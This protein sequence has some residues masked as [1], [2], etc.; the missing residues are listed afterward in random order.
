MQ[1]ELT[2]ATQLKLSEIFS[3]LQGEGP[4]AGQ[5]CVFL[6]L[7]LCNLRCDWCDTKYTWDFKAY[8]YEDEVREQPVAEVA[9]RLRQL[10]PRHLVITGGEPLLQQA[11]LANLLS[12]LNPEVFVE[13]ET[14]GTL[15]PN[16]M[17]CQRVQH[18]NVSPKLSNSGEA[19]A[20]RLRPEPLLR[21][22]ALEGAWLKLVLQADSDW[23]EAQALITATNW[24]LQR[25]LLMPQ[26]NQPSELTARSAPIAALAVRHGVRFSTRLQL[27]LWDGARGT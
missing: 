14:N 19:E 7:A 18:W 5:A 11:A 26:A 16:E 9:A 25:V 17:L 20:R 24:P 23:A 1:S 6:R 15:S 22:R 12:Q 2:N 8:R 21:L 4:H 27:L 13:V 3:S 10:A